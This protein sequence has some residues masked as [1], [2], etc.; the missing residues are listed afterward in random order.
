MTLFSRLPK[1]ALSSNVEP[2]INTSN[3]NTIYGSNLLS[4]WQANPSGITVTQ[5]I[6][7]QSSS[8]RIPIHIIQLESRISP[9]VPNRIQNLSRLGFP[10]LRR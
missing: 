2:L 8:P 3:A 7:A 9:I 5:V 1:Y 10:Y 6:T 4:V